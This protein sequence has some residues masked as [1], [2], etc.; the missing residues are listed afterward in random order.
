M[1]LLFRQIFAI[2]F[3][4]FALLAGARADA[5]EG[6]FDPTF[7]GGGRELVAVSVLGKL[8]NLGRLIVRT[9]GK[10]L[11]G[12]TCEY[13]DPVTPNY[14]ESTFCVSQLLPSGAYD[15]N[16]GPGGLG[17]VQ[18]N[19]FATWPANTTMN[20]MIILRDGRIALL[21]TVSDD[22]TVEQVF[23][24]GI[25]RA[26]GTALDST[27]GAGS[28][29]I[30][31][32]FGGNPGTALS[33]VQQSDGKILVA[34]SATGINGNSDFA[35][36]RV[37]SDLSG[38]DTSFG[39]AGAQLVAFDLGGPSGN[40]N[41]QCGTVRLQSDGKIVLGGYAPTSTSMNTSSGPA[42]AL[43]RLTSDGAR[44]PT[45][46]TTGDGRLHYTAGEDLA[47]AFDVRI[48]A[49]D[50]IV[51]AGESAYAGAT[52]SQWVI[53]RLSRDGTTDT[54]FNQ[55][56]AQHILPAPG[57]SGYARR[58][59][60]TNDG[61]FAIGITPRTPTSSSNYFVVARLNLD[62][63]RDPRFGYNGLTY[64]SFTSTNDVDTDAGDIM[65]GNGGLMIA[66]TESQSAT[67]GTTIEKFAIG[68]L[69]YDQIF[70]YG[71]Q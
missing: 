7:A 32:S 16:F 10:L 64:G 65:V 12:G 69:Q 66:G 31:N 23:L 9:D 30:K 21:G 48:D 24:L 39:S 22:N 53:D 5:Q 27:V 42:I 57:Y 62:G 3:S 33:L 45:F 51:L 6:N 70:S 1:R 29:Y 2:A 11:L 37:L 43:T 26:D 54:S 49:N 63:S 44:D 56:N 17:Y 41:D 68:R 15:G 40:N 60:L 46:G 52:T 38:L 4:C 67:G 14:F 59:T 55:G 58:L 71:F 13:E 19:R 61:I 20:D 36:A 25:L 47:V 8:D 34:G 18:F 50:R 35:V 28:G